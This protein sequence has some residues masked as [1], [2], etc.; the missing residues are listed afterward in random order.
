[1]V[2]A[3][4]IPFRGA[5]HITG[6]IVALAAARSVALDSRRRAWAEAPGASGLV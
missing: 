6:R 1:L 3:L 2:Q 5:H 4:K